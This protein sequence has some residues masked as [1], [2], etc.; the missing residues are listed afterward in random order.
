MFLL[1]IR[2]LT[3]DILKSALGT[4]YVLLFSSDTIT[5]MSGHIGGI[6]TL[7]TELI[8]LFL[9]FEQAKSPSSAPSVPFL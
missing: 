9:I 6:K 5:A 7:G 2:Q 1:T 3:A 4:R 8:G